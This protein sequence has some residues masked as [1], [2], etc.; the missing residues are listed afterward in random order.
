V[1][2]SS[3]DPHD[4]PRLR[5]ER[6]CCIL[7]HDNMFTPNNLL[8]PTAMGAQARG[9]ETSGLVY[10]GRAGFFDL[11]RARDMID[12]TRFIHN[13]PTASV[14]PPQVIRTILGIVSIRRTPSDPAET[15]AAIAFDDALDH[16][17]VSRDSLTWGGRNSSF[18]LEDLVSNY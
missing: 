16:A 4:E 3:L 8:D 12:L 5:G 18:S 15:A 11:G 6:L 7:A 10:C 13:Q 17:I 1:V 2:D 14:G 9:S